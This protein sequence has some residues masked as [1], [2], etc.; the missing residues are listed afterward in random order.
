MV[1]ARGN[2]SGIATTTIVIA[3][4]KAPISPE[5][6]SRWSGW[7]PWSVNILIINAISVAT[8]DTTPT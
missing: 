4:I 5:D 7:R 2:P 6:N 8:A 1:T 3:K